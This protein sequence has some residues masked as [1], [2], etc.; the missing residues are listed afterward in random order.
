M[1]L[2]WLFPEHLVATYKK[3]QARAAYIGKELSNMKKLITWLP[4]ILFFLAWMTPAY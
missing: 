2:V 1:S 3:L 4:W